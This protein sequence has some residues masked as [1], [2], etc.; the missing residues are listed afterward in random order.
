MSKYIFL[1]IDGVLNYNN[2]TD[3]CFGMTGIED[4]LVQK[5]S[6]NTSDFAATDT[7]TKHLAVRGVFCRV[8]ILN[9]RVLF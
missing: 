4:R 3:D 2:T 9:E 7:I 8:G 1:D 5:L 6:T